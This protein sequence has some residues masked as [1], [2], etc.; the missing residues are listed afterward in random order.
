MK[1]QKKGKKRPTPARKARK[2]RLSPAPGMTPGEIVE[3]APLM[4]PWAAPSG[5][6]LDMDAGDPLADSL[7]EAAAALRAGRP[8]E[9]FSLCRRV[10]AAEPD[11][12]DALNLAGVAVFQT[13]DGA[14]VRLIKPVEGLMVLFPSYF[15]H[16]TLPFESDEVRISIAFDV[17]A[18]E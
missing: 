4:S 6:A 1:K 16:R 5:P 9:A 18:R 13:G 17:L 2:K 3:I 15:Y 10:L 14:E 12:A 11:N 8:E 7:A